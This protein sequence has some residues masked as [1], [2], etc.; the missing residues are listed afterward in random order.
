MRSKIDIF[1]HKKWTTS[2]ML[3]CSLYGSGWACGLFAGKILSQAR[4]QSFNGHLQTHTSAWFYISHNLG[5]VVILI[6]SAALP[7]LGPGLVLFGNG[8]FQ[9]AIGTP[10]ILKYGLPFFLAGILPHGVFEMLAWILAG[11]VSFL[12]SQHV[13]TLIIQIFFPFSREGPPSQEIYSPDFRTLFKQLL[14]LSSST[15]LLLC[16]AGCLEAYVSPC[17]A[18]HFLP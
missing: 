3:S 9:G 14:I 10:V 17:L 12:L 7:F 1:N 13:Y 18:S 8:L 4:L 6:L 15:G 2:F 16:L 5:V 11:A